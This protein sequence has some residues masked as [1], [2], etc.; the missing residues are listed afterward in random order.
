VRAQS[1][2]ARAVSIDKI[3]SPAE[4]EV[5]LAACDER[6]RL[7]V[8]QCRGWEIDGYELA[9]LTGDTEVTIIRKRRR[10]D[11]EVLFNLVIA[12]PTMTTSVPLCER[13]LSYLAVAI[14]EVMA[15]RAS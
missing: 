10:S 8:E 14:D 4:D 13:E 12:S 6:D 11:G 15:R 2:G 1:E 9:S 7:E 5:Y 3:W